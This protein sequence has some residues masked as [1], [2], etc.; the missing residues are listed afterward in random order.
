NAQP[1]E[2]L[3]LMVAYTYTESKEIS[4]MPGSNASSAYNN[5]VTVNGP[6]LP[7]LQRSQYVV[8]HKVIGSAGYR[9]PWSNDFAKSATLINIF[10]SGYSPDG[11]SYTYSKDMNGDGLASDLIYI[12]SGRGDIK[13]TTQADED[14]FFNF[15]EQ[16]RYLRNNKGKYAEANA[17]RSPWVHNFDLRLVREYY[18][19]VGETKNTLQFSLDFLNVGNIIN[20]EWGISKRNNVTNNGKILIYDGK[21]A[22]NVP[23]YSFNKFNGDYPVNSFDYNYFYGETWKLQVGVKYSF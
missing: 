11:Y 3:R 5:L 17:V 2:D 9:L 20:S 18:I 8:P 4:G 21:D 14:A 12:P 7:E 23:S 6:H 19:N 22:N 1:V 10:Y 13:F 16:D 15:M